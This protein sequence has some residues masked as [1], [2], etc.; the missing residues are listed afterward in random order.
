MVHVE[1]PVSKNCF[2]FCMQSRR[3]IKQKTIQIKYIWHSAPLCEDILVCEEGLG[4]RGD[5]TVIN[6]FPKDLEGAFANASP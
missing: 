3:E 1:L 5:P 2:L 6:Q 4:G